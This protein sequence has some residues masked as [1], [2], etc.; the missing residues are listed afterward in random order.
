[1]VFDIQKTSAV[2][3]KRRMKPSKKTFF[4]GKGRSPEILRDFRAEIGKR[5]RFYVAAL[6]ENARFCRTRRQNRFE[7]TEE[8]FSTYK[9]LPWLC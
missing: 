6:C 1:V 7:I 4:D 5:K 3:A 9:S 8:R 2:S